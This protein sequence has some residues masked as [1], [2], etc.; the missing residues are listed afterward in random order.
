VSHINT[1]Y[2]SI[3]IDFMLDRSFSLKYR[4]VHE[5][6]PQMLGAALLV[7]LLLQTLAAMSKKHKSPSDKKPAYI[8][9]KRRSLI[10]SRS[11]RKHDVHTRRRNMSPA[12]QWKMHHHSDT[13]PVPEP[14]QIPPLFDTLPSE[15]KH[16]IIKFYLDTE[17]LPAKP[18]RC[19]Y[20]AS[21]FRP[22]DG[23][24]LATSIPL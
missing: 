2:R 5:V 21:S 3:G 22:Y 10:P 11:S 12:L 23:V 8:M 4:Y 19:A 16:K 6:L 20:D 15:I 17:P 24:N 9:S 7:A 14:R 18:R 13:L 1:S